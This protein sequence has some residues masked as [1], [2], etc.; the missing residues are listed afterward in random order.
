MPAGARALPRALQGWCERGESNPHPLRDWILSPARLP[1]PPLSQLCVLKVPARAFPCGARA[2]QGGKNQ[3]GRLPANHQ[4]TRQ[5]NKGRPCCQ[6]RFR[7]RAAA[8][9]WRP[10]LRMPDRLPLRPFGGFRG[11]WSQRRVQ[12][13][14]E[15][16]SGHLDLGCGQ[17]GDGCFGASRARRSVPAVFQLERLSERAQVH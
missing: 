13:G 9:A 11:R 12:C 2:E 15:K 5:S 4:T 7:Q 16:L 17:P 8:P 3:M 10:R 6:L 14:T 1:I